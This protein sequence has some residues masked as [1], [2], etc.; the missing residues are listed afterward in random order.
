MSRHHW[1]VSPAGVPLPPDFDGSRARQEAERGQRLDAEVRVRARE[2]R[3]AKDEVRL[4]E[5][6]ANLDGYVIAKG[7]EI[8]AP[9]VAAAHAAVDERIAEQ[10][11]ELQR[12]DD[13][14][15][16]LRRQVAALVRQLQG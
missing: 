10:N 8:A 7:Q 16:E 15:H 13:V 2:L 5:M 6:I 11:G 9:L 4:A 14:I 1:D 3:V 12:R